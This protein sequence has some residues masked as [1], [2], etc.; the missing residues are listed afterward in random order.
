MKAMG[1]RDWAADARLELIEL[2]KPEPGKHDVRVSVQ[3]I[4]VNPV[5]WK[6]RSSG[7]LRLAAR[8][9]GPK[10]PVVVGVDFAGVVDSVGSQGTRVVPGDRVVGGTD[11]SR[12][13]R[14]SYADTVLVRE[15]QVCR[16]PDSVDIAIAGALP[17]PG[18]TAWMSV[19]DLGRIRQASG[20]ER[21]V[22]VLGASGGVGQ[23]AVQIA[24]LESAFVV[25]VCSSKNIELVKGL[26]ADVVVD[27]TQGDALAQAGEHGPFQVIVDCAGSYPASRCRA[28][29]SAHGR[30]IMV[31]G[32]SPDSMLQI[33]VPPFKSKSILGRPTGARLEPLVAAVAAGKLRVNIAKKLPLTSAE[34]AHELSRSGRLTGNIILEPPTPTTP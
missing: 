33:V 1:Q 12:G 26:G 9:L 2:P 4:G 34:E 6:M 20:S 5:D 30:H 7:P 22:L 10:P 17:I 18:V 24:K 27:Y 15:D 23:L 13:Q 31:A 16:V 19:V 3:A 8:L 32:D 21:R 14:G 28:L 29:L 25:G 11:F